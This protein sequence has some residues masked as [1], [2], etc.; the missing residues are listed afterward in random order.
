MQV[1]DIMGIWR[2]GGQVTS[3]AVGSCMLTLHTEHTASS[4]KSLTYAVSLRAQFW[5]GWFEWQWPPW[6]H[7]FE[8]AVPS[9]WN[10]LRRIRVWPCWSRHVTGGRASVLSTPVFSWDMSS[11]LLLLPS[12]YSAVL[13]SNPLELQTQLNTCC[14][15]GVLSQQ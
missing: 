8:Y 3:T 5:P 7:M 14:G 12:L 10:C 11:E 2:S 6:A 13:D 1:Q 4:S 9:W 15:H